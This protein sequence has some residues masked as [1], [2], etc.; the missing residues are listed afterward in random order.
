[1]VLVSLELA[2]YTTMTYSSQ[3]SPCLCPTG[4]ETEAY[5][6]FLVS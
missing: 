5:A 6:V 4:A 3:T 1:M 2:V